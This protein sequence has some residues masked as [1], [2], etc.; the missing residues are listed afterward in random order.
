M[1]HRNNFTNELRA[2]NDSILKFTDS[3]DVANF[4]DTW[5]E[6]VQLF[7]MDLRNYLVKTTK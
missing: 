6:E 1:N 5:D 3:G 4:F 7:I 2:G